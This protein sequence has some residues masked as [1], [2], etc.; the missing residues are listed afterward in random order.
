MT[1]QKKDFIEVEF[2]GKTKDGEIFDSNIKKNLEKLNPDANPKPL[3]FSLGEGMFLKGI[4]DFLIGKEISKYTIE[5]SPEKAFGPRVKEFVQMVPIKLFH[6]Q[7]L[8][9]VPGAVF[10]FDGRIAKVLSVSSGRVMIDFN[11][12]LAG[13][14]VTY[15][16]N[17]L[18]KVDDINEKAK[19]LIEFLFRR[20]FKFSVKD[21]KLIIEV[22]KNLAQLIE[23]FKEKFKDILDLDLEV[24][25]I[26][27]PVKPEQ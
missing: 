6:S 24:K 22:E 17:V 21:K 4:D 19:S 18:R 16:I 5:L 9:P 10:N 7:N 20:E 27:N 13:K 26:K 25:E 3:I 14:E 23:M 8:N 11:N 1:M 15:E 2:T 12:P